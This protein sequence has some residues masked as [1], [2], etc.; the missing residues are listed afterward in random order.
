MSE[1]AT[2]AEDALATLHVGDHVTDADDDSDVTMLVVD[3]EPRT[4]A[5]T[6]V[7]AERTVADVNPEYDPEEQNIGVVFPSRGDVLLE[8]LQSYGYPRSRLERV[9]PVHEE[10][11]DD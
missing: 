2:A 8:S 5:E 9:Q 1:S 7:D 6:P 11:S 4:I 10:G 3:T